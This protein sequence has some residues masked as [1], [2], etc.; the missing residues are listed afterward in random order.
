MLRLAPPVVVS[1]GGLAA[2]W[3]RASARMVVVTPG[4]N[5]LGVVVVGLLAV[6]I[7]VVVAR[8]DVATAVILFGVVV[9]A[10]AGTEL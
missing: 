2:G 6:F 8:V 4:I 7:T 3:L 10:T 5:G 1:L 9:V